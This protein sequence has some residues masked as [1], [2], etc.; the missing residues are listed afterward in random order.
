MTTYYVTEGRPFCAAPDEHQDCAC[1]G[2]GRPIVVRERPTWPASN[3]YVRVR[4]ATQAEAIALATTR[5]QPVCYSGGAPRRIAP[6]LAP[7]REVVGGVV[8]SR[9]I[10][11]HR[12]EPMRTDLLDTA[13][14]DIEG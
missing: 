9:M 7:L 2:R 12:A 4:A 8:T 10:P 11:T 5:P 13:D 14:S 6:E 1:G 3:A